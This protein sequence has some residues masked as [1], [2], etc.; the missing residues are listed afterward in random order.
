M[1]VTVCE[2]HDES[3]WLEGDWA[4]LVAH[5][6]AESSELVLLP[7]F[8]FC[9]WF[10]TTAHFTPAAWDAAVHI[11]EEWLARLG[12]LAPATVLGTRPATRN[13]RR[14]NEV[15]VWD[16]AGGYRAAHWKV[17][18]PNVDGAWEASWYERGKERSKPVKVGP[19]LVGFQICSE[20]WA[21][22]WAQAYGQEGAH[23]II[24]PRATEIYSLDKFLAGGRVSALVSGAFSLSSNRRSAR[25]GIANFGGQGWIVGPN[26]DVLGL[27]SAERPLVTVDIDLEDA[28]RA[29]Q[30]Y[31]RDMLNL[32]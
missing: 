8:P 25:A 30:T 16:R 31:P 20:L 6:R 17:Y 19:A 11:H 18:V 4:A 29:K 32:V 9:T 22:D 13:G 15:F 7:E 1:K 5:V 12:E 3:E 27:T 26:G 23:I 2:L 28:D 14:L 21:M 10:P 24:T